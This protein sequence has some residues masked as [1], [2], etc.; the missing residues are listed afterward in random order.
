MSILEELVPPLDLTLDPISAQLLAEC[1]DADRFGTGQI[2][3]PRIR[4]VLVNARNSLLVPPL[5]VANDLN[6]VLLSHV[7][8][9]LQKLQLVE[10]DIPVGVRN[11]AGN[12]VAIKGTLGRAATASDAAAL[13]S[14]F[15]A[16]S[17]VLPV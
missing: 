13:G 16:L 15:I 9:R 7:I 17:G 3:T 11:D 10:G 5:D 4:D 8:A 1:L 6:V 2:Q 12:Y 14:R